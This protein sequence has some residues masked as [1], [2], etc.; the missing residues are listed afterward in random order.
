MH[1]DIQNENIPL[2]LW[3]AQAKLS[4]FPD[5]GK[6]LMVARSVHLTLWWHTHFHDVKSIWGHPHLL[7][8]VRPNVL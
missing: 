2:K 1:I 5:H 8:V 7:M 6:Q 4:L 3:G